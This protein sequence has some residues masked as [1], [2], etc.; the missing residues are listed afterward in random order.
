MF[1]NSSNWSDAEK[2]FQGCYIKCKEYGDTLV[3]IKKVT[4]EA[5]WGVDEYEQNVCI[6]LDGENT[7]THGYELDYI[8]PKKAY[9]QYGAHAYFLSRIP[10]RMWKKGLSS[11]NTTIQS[12][13]LNGHSFT[14]FHLKYLK[15]FVNKPGYVNYKEIT[16]Q[17]SVALSPRFAM[18]KTD[19]VIFLDITQIGCYN[20]TTN[21]VVV[22]KLFLDDVKPLFVGAKFAT[23]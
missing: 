4:P 18:R 21:T 2:Y 3:L 22:P 16:D 9:F 12:L 11:E 20:K 5:L 1:V 14:S 13:G 15:G 17:T 7:G 19:G 10:A 8:L 6:E 23:L